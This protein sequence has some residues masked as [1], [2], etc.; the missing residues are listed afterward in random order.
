MSPE[1]IACE[2]SL[3]NDRMAVDD[4]IWSASW[5]LCLAWELPGKQ[6]MESEETRDVRH[7]SCQSTGHLDTTLCLHARRWATARAIVYDRPL[8]FWSRR[9]LGQRSQRPCQHESGNAPLVGCR[10]C[11]RGPP[12]G[13]PRYGAVRIE[14][15]PKAVVYG[16]RE[17]A[18]SECSGP[19]QR[20]TDR[21]PIVKSLKTGIFEQGSRRRGWRGPPPLL[22]GN[23]VNSTGSGGGAVS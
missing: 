14:E 2:A 9:G 19:N 23:L 3:V 15:W 4:T 17:V 5:L 22:S 18:P 12:N 13:L 11:G 21:G 8:K 7:Q 10:P 20:S 16:Q 6:L 1:S